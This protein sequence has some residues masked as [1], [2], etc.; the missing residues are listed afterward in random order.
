MA[1]IPL[2]LVVNGEKV[3]PVEVDEYTSLLDFLHEFLNLTG[4]KLGCGIGVCRAC[5]ILVERENGSLEP[6]RSCINNIGRF[7]GAKVTT[8]EGQAERNADGEIVA[9]SAVQEA[10][11]RNFSFQCGW[12]TAGFVNGA[13]ALIDRLKREPVA[14]ENVTNAIEEALGEHICRCTGYVRYF[15]AVKEVIESTPGLVKEGGR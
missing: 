11:L 1:K 13:T 14:A 8:V 2:S 4:T 9:L 12:C 7:N 6:V 10:F 3:G 15:R 5:T